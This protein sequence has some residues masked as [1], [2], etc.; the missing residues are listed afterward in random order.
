MKDFAV[1]GSGIGGSSIAALLSAKGFDVILFEKEAYL[2]GCS[3]SFSHKGHIYNTGATTLAGYETNGIVK[4]VFDTIGLKPELIRTDP[5]IVVIQNAKV[6]PRFCDFEKFFAHLDA[7]Y[8]HEKNREFWTLI[9]EI[10]AAFY[11]MQGHYYSNASFFSKLKSLTSFLPLFVKFQKYLRVSAAAF[12]KNFFTEIS[13]EY[14][15]FMESQV[16]IVSQAGLKEINFFTA[17]LSLG[18]TFHDT[19]Y[20]KGGFSTLFDAIV[21]NVNEV[22]RN[23]EI[24]SIEKHDSH[25]SL[26]T[27]QGVFEAKKIILN[28]TVYESAK[29]FTSDEVK[30]Y[31]KKYE[32]LDNHQSSFMLYMTFKS[33][34]H[35]FH[36]Y[37]LIQNEQI[38]Y[39]LSN[40]VFV[41]FSDKDDTKIAPQGHYSIT[42]SIHTDSR[43]WENQ[44]T[45]KS[46][47]KEL[48]SFL[49]NTIIAIL[50]IEKESVMSCFSATPKTFQR[51]INRSQLGGNA[52]TMKN[53]LPF[54]PS[55]DT[56]I[57][58][59]YNVGDSVYAAQGWPGVMLGVKNLER[60]LDA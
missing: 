59:L 20:V 37:Q 27:K 57:E 52:I 23:A 4:D 18:Y 16:F 3:S 39:T 25:Y 54:L 34:K 53:F 50:K 45:Y 60:L 51:Y 55:N 40:A 36:H 44:Q 29:L 10:D 32:K 47:K 14:L 12:I 43:F 9:Y 30:N 2:G 26:H 41:S 58:G 42:A 11:G 21:K 13:E 15:Q 46:Q 38:K 17:A 56:P 28:A 7:N 5:A 33:E 48:E 1:V 22:Q 24:L 31:Y 35:F 8:P 19:Y 6:T 49:F